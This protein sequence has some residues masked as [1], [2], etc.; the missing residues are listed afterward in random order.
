MCSMDHRLINKGQRCGWLWNQSTRR[1]QSQTTDIW[2]R[3]QSLLVSEEDLQ[4]KVLRYFITLVELQSS[5]LFHSQNTNSDINCFEIMYK[6]QF[7]EI[8]SSAISTAETGYT[9]KY[10]IGK[11]TLIRMSDSFH[12]S[13]LCFTQFCTII[14]HL[15]NTHWTDHHPDPF[16]L[17]SS[18][19]FR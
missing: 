3:S 5:S 14:C 2:W 18:S 11:V 19:E 6:C 8:T 16:W 7:I 10:C 13:L 17:L 12:S 9:G 1:E 15:G 4:S